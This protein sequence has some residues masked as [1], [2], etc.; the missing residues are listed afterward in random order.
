MDLIT[1]KIV[2]LRCESPAELKQKTNKLQVN[3]SVDDERLI[4]LIS[5]YLVLGFASFLTKILVLTAVVLLFFDIDHQNIMYPMVKL[6]VMIDVMTN[7]VYIYLQYAFAEKKYRKLC[8]CVDR[9]VDSISTD[10]AVRRIRRDTFSFYSQRFKGSLDLTEQ[11]NSASPLSKMRIGLPGIGPNLKIVPTNSALS[12][13]DNEITPRLSPIESAHA[14]NADMD[15]WLDFGNFKKQT[16][17]NSQKSSGEHLEGNHDK[18]DSKSMEREVERSE[19]DGDIEAQL[20]MF[21][22][23]SIEIEEYGD[24][25]MV[26]NENEEDRKSDEIDGNKSN[27]IGDKIGGIVGIIRRKSD[28]II[29]M[30]SRQ[31]TEDVVSVPEQ[32]Y[33]EDDND[34]D[35]DNCHR[36]S[37]IGELKEIDDRYISTAL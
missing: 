3:L 2:S 24:N 16:M 30:I 34:N 18:G 4:K 23:A 6:S 9:H 21:R 5:K 35:N 33:V 11:Q 27:D 26:E 12:K 32:S 31:R 37:Q 8:G 1:S 29:E 25:G 28:N 19:S 15:K 10:N 14:A 13:D 20:E 7:I 17:E 22:T 36:I